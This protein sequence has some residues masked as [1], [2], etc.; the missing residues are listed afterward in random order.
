VALRSR[1]KE[2]SNSVRKNPPGNLHLKIKSPGRHVNQNRISAPKMHPSGAPV[3][4]GFEGPKYYGC[5]TAKRQLRK[6]LTPVL[7]MVYL[8]QMRMG[9]SAAEFSRRRAHLGFGVLVLLHV[10]ILNG[11]R[12]YHKFN[13]NIGRSK[14]V[15]AL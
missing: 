1:E 3:F 14:L 5:V 8:A 15:S 11:S 4:L 10:V 13:C 7:C 9:T 6:S 12:L 2:R